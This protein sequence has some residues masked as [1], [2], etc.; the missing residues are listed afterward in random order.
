[1]SSDVYKAQEGNP[2][3]KLITFWEVNWDN[4]QIGFTWSMDVLSYSVCSSI[5]AHVKAQ[6]IERKT[7]APETSRHEDVN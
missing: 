5:R 3:I 7:E 2:T 1:M 4:Y 6:G